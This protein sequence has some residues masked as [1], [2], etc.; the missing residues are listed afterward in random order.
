MSITTPGTECAHPKRHIVTDAR[1]TEQRTVSVY[2]CPSY[3][4]IQAHLPWVQREGKTGR[5]FVV[6]LPP[7]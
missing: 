7:V 2:S 6:P 1:P 3:A 5:A 4:C